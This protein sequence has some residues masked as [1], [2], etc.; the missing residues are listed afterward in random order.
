MTHASSAGKCVLITGG[1][2]RLGKAMALRFA[3][4][5]WDIALHYHRSHEQALASKAEIEALGQRCALI[6]GDLSD[7]HAPKDIFARSVE[8]LG[9]VDAVINNASLFEYDNASEFSAALLNQHLGPNL[10]APIELAQQLHQHI[11]PHHPARQGVVINLL[12]QKLWGYNPDFFS[13][14][15][16]KAALQSATTMLAQGLAPFVRVVGLAPGLT[17]PSHMQS[18]DDFART[19]ALAPLGRASTPDDIANAALMLA[20]NTSITGSSLVVDGG[21]HL[22]GLQRDFSLL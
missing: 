6:Q 2:Q 7:A 8:A 9:R 14:T 12:D 21:Q 18:E 16:C 1:A 5:G 20:E 4:Q 10:V 22:M 11:Q 3:S 13:Y 15:L 17:M 19:H